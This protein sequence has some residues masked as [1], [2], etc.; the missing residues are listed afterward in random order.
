LSKVARFA[1]SD[2]SR[3]GRLRRGMG[4]DNSS[5]SLWEGEEFAVYP[6]PPKGRGRCRRGRVYLPK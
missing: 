3:R 4:S 6:P 5:P 2:L 1:L